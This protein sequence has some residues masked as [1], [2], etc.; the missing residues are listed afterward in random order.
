MHHGT[1][2]ASL[3]VKCMVVG[4]YLGTPFW[5][6]VPMLYCKVKF[7]FVEKGVLSDWIDPLYKHAL[8]IKQPSA[9]KQ[10]VSSNNKIGA[11]PG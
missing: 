9:P 1:A 8:I 4:H 10:H 3:S 7:L 11:R 2:Y 5:V 6:L